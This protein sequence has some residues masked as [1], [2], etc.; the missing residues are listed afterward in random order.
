LSERHAVLRRSEDEGRRH[1]REVDH[2]P[3][4]AI[5]VKGIRLID[6]IDADVACGVAGDA[7]YGAAYEPDILPPGIGLHRNEAFFIGEEFTCAEWKLQLYG[8]KKEIELPLLADTFHRGAGCRKRV[9]PSDCQ[10]KL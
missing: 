3:G 9:W 7:K 4:G 5:H 8:V 2:R 10:A 6:E 1:D